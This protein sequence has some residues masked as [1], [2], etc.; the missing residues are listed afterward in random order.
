MNF[1]EFATNIFNSL[2]PQSN[3]V[4]D[5]RLAKLEE[6]VHAELIAVVE[7]AYMQINF[8]MI[9]PI[10]CASYYSTYIT[11]QTNSMVMLQDARF[12]AI[13]DDM[14]DQQ[15]VFDYSFSEYDG[16]WSLIV[17]NKGIV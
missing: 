12:R 5:N 17:S 7:R 16:T 9:E 3:Q 1:T 8:D 4:N 14:L 10:I 2:K 6:E 15:N 11:G 13:L